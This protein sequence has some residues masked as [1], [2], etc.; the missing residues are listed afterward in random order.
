MHL[1]SRDTIEWCIM[2]SQFLSGP[3]ITLA[4]ESNKKPKQSERLTITEPAI[5]LGV[6]SSSLD[7]ILDSCV[8]L[9]YPFL[10]CTGA[11]SIKTSK[12]LQN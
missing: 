8:T 3:N 7:D 1:I 9:P 5:L 2:R 10:S 11:N 4:V 12:N 6:D